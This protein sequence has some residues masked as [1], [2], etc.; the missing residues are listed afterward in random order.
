MF[1]RASLQGERI[2]YGPKKFYKIDTCCWRLGL[3]GRPRNF[4]WSGIRRVDGGPKARTRPPQN[5]EAQ[6]AA[7]TQLHHKM[8][9]N[10][11]SGNVQWFG[12]HS[13]SLNRSS[14]VN[15]LKTF[16]I[17]HQCSVKLSQSF[18]I[19]QAFLAWSNICGQVWGFAEKIS[20][21]QILDNVEKTFDWE[22]L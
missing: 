10:L 17:R 5:D 12:S 21:L 2:H 11:D 14:V 9:N 22:M 19:A 8:L 1:E 13:S 3:G 7:A 4:G 15:V 20:F 16:F 18:G 6:N